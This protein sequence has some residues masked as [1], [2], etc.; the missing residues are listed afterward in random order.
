[1]NPLYVDMA[2][3]VFYFFILLLAGYLV[4]KKHRKDSAVD[5]LTGGHSLN[6]F[7]TGLTLIAMG[8]DTGIMG[9]TG[10]AFVWGMS[11][12]WNAVNLWITAPLAAMFLIPIYWRTKI[13]TTPELLEKRFNVSCRVFFSIVMSVYM[14]V[15]LGTSIYLGALMLNEIFGWHLYMCCAAIM[16]ITGLYVVMGGMKTVLSINIYQAVF[17][18]LTLTMVAAMV[19]YKVGGISVIASIKTCN[20]AGIILPSTL[21]PVDFRIDSKLWYPLPSGFIWAVLAG[22]A[23]IACNFGMVQ[24]L[25]AA[26]S[27]QDAQKAILFTGL[28]L[29]GLVVGAYMVGVGV[30]HLMPDI[31]PDKA[32]IKAVLTMF[33]MG[34]RGMIIAGLMAS[35]LST[36]DGLVTASSTMVTQDIYLRFFKP[37]ASDK[38]IKM[39]ARSTQLVVIISALVLIPYAAESRTVTKLIQSLVADMFGVIIALYMVGIFS[40]RATPKAAL[41]A[42]VS[43]ICL[44]IYLDFG[45]DISFP[46]VGIFSFVFS[47]IM[48]LVLSRFEKPPT[49]E[50]LENLT[51][52]TIPGVK[53]PF[54]GLAAWP[55]L[56]K[57][58]AAIAGFWLILT[59]AWEIYIRTI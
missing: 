12:Q 17:I 14:I 26:K 36:I 24:R 11:V 50:K 31:L 6:W 35:L 53:G 34:V 2:V 16:V 25:L 7:K 52:Y 38:K 43:G 49:K 48:A 19:I 29:T 46:N 1:M 40:T 3:V 56:W 55:N 20:E 37:D 42:M 13:I 27:E 18:T 8:I 28:G 30:R 9:I 39:F 32:Y 21:M 51:V 23:W 33:P 57:A 54:V 47:V 10:I 58:I 41:T 15:V 45:T 59:A 22:T 4:G 44:A 5:F